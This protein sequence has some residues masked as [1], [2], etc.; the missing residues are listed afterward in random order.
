MQ[1]VHIVTMCFNGLMKEK[2]QLKLVHGTHTFQ[3]PGK[4]GTENFRTS[5]IDHIPFTFRTL[6]TVGPVHKDSDIPEQALYSGHYKEVEQAILLR[7]R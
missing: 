3:S 1:V 6:V 2:M 7:H 4:N 5:Y